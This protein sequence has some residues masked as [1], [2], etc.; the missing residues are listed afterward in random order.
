MTET[1]SRVAASIVYG[2]DADDEHFIRLDAGDGM[3]EICFPN[4]EGA[5]VKV[6]I[7]RFIPTMTGFIA[8]AA[9]I[10]GSSEPPEP[11]AIPIRG[12]FKL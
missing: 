6:P 3:V 12:R 2:A 8:M 5:E 1:A 10:Q 7:E 11:D 9:Q 4:I